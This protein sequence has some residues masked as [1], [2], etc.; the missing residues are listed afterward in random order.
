[1]TLGIISYG[2]YIPPLR[3]SKEEYC[4]A[5]GSIRSRVQ[6]KAVMDFD[7]DTVTMAIEAGRRV[8]ENLDPHSV[9]IL[10]LASTSLPYSYRSA[11]TA[12]ATALGL[13][14]DIFSA[15][16]TQSTKAGTEALLMALAAMRAQNLRTGLVIA[17]DSPRANTADPLD[18]ELGAAAVSLALS[19]QGVLAE[20]DGCASY[21]SEYLGQRFRTAPESNVRDL[22]IAQYSIA[23][24]QAAIQ[25]AAKQ[26]Q[27]KVGVM[28]KDYQRIVLPPIRGA[29][30]ALMSAG[31]AKQQIDDGAMTN[32]VGDTGA[33]SALLNL[34]AVLDKSDTGDRI[35]L[36]SYGYGS[37]SDAVSIRVLQQTE[38]AQSDL[39]DQMRECT[40]IDYVQYLKLGGGLE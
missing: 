31:F 2:C 18:F 39:Q 29:D 19:N 6:A 36:V 24:V 10:C 20:V 1:M 12:V 23:G 34:V 33:C 35:L 14:T 17:T 28:P 7:E 38:S 4:K 9:D 16:F 11:A 21:A 30:G 26:L 5:W 13:R 25:G 3:L 40:Y 22:G 32:Q 15:E 37:A 27:V 8:V